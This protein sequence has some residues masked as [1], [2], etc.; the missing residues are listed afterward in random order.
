MDAGVRNPV[1]LTGDVHKHWAADVKTDYA[2]PDAPVF[3]TELVASSITSGGNGNAAWSDPI[4]EW[5]PHL[6][7]SG[8]LRGYLRTTV[9]PD[10]LRADFRSVDRVTTRGGAVATQASFEVADGQRGLRPVG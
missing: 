7:F 1:V 6:R 3:G 9:T 5:N 4:M 10:G 8:D 2:D